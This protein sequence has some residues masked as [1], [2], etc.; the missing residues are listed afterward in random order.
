MKKA[1]TVS[2]LLLCC[3]PVWAISA[4]AVHTMRYLFNFWHSPPMPLTWGGAA[5]ETF[6]EF[7]ALYLS[8]ILITYWKQS[9][10]DKQSAKSE[11]PAL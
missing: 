11:P 6:P 9:K 7:L 1:K 4:L 3:L 2:A 10:R 8:I 5:A